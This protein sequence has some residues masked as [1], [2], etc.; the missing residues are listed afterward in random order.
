MKKQI[1][2]NFSASLQSLAVI[3]AIFFLMAFA[4]KDEN[5]KSQDSDRESENPRSGE[6]TF[7]KDVGKKYGMRDPR[8][9]ANTKAPTT[10]AITTSL[11]TKYFMC[12]DEGEW[13]N[14]LYL[15]EDVRV[16]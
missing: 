7:Q 10:G 5:N 14:N 9:C 1:K 8:V 6:F 11:A 3:L 2:S 16:E 15:V 13:S 12:Q 4:C